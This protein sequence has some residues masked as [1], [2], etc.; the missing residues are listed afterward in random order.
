MLT[1]RA[2]NPDTGRLVLLYGLTA[3][4]CQRLLAGQ[5]IH[6]TIQTGGLTTEVVI[7]AAATAADVRALVEGKR[8][9]GREHG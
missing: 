2:R 4:E 1:R 6:T 7:L 8:P 9:G 5:P 3:D